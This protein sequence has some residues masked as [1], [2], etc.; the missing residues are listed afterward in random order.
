MATEET[1]SPKDTDSPAQSTD[2]VDR[3]ETVGPVRASDRPRVAS[4]SKPFTDHLTQ[5]FLFLIALIILGSGIG[6]ASGNFSTDDLTDILPIVL[7]PLFT[8]LGT[9]VAFHYTKN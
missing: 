7:T 4:P 9:A 6:L 3:I 8:L 1:E 2:L 5:M